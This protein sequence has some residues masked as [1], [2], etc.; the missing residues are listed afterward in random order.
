MGIGEDNA[1]IRIT[2]HKST[3]LP[4]YCSWFPL[5]PL[6]MPLL[7]FPFPPPPPPPPPLRSPPPTPPHSPP[8]GFALPPP[9][10]PVTRASRLTLEA[11]AGTASPTLRCPPRLKTLSLISLALL[12]SLLLPCPQLLNFPLP[13]LPCFIACANKQVAVASDLQ[14]APPTPQSWS[15]LELIETVTK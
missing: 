6:L 13:T 14:R 7:T 1:Q 5:S 9:K 11:A 12:S 8:P 3:L 10:T 4:Q 15:W 2:L